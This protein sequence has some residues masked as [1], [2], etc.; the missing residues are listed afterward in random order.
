M[1]TNAELAEHLREPTY[2][3]LRRFDGM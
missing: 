1:P 3:I 2:L